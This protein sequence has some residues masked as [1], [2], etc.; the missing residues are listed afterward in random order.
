MNRSAASRSR[1][2]PGRPAARRPGSST[3]RSCWPAASTRSR[4]QSPAV[5]ATPWPARPGSR[6]PRPASAAMRSAAST[7]TS[8]RCSPRSAQPRRRCSRRSEQALARAARPEPWPCRPSIQARFRAGRRCGSGLS[9]TILSSTRPS[10]PRRI[11]S[12]SKRGRASW[13]QSCRLTRSSRPRAGTWA[14][15]SRRFLPR[16]R[17]SREVPPPPRSM[18]SRSTS[19]GSMPPS[20]G[21]ATPIS[22]CSITHRSSAT[23]S[24]PRRTIRRPR[25]ICSPSSSRWP[26][27]R[28]A[29][30]A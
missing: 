10:R 20:A 19:A 4:P 18:R 22:S 2:W 25:P 9:P 29:R 11:P 23:A 12:R 21:W 8:R 7:W 15:R 3:G 26:G 30:P 14:A 16:S 13:R 17:R 6:P 28:A 27:W 24:S 5:R 1:S